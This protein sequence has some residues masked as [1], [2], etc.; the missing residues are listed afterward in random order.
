MTRQ[1]FREFPFSVTLAAGSGGNAPLTH[2]V[3][4]RPA[5]LAFNPTTRVL[6]GTPD[7]TGTLNLVYLVRDTDGDEATDT[8]RIT[9][10][11]PD[12]VVPTDGRP[13]A[14]AQPQVEAV[15]ET[16]LKAIWVAPDAG[17]AAISTYN[18]RVSKS[19]E[20]VWT[21]ATS[22]KSPYIFKELEQGTKYKIQVRAVNS[23]GASNWSA[24]GLAPTHILLEATEAKGGELFD[25]RTDWDKEIIYS[26]KNNGK[27][28]LF[29]NHTDTTGI[30]LTIKTE[31]KTKGAENRLLETD[32]DVR[33]SENVE[34][35]IRGAFDPAVYNDD[36]GRLRF[37]VTKI[38]DDDTLITG[39]AIAILRYP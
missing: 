10:A 39:V 30:N 37:T 23:V 20:D 32:D 18:L 17:D 33:K 19:S 7:A 26:V 34:N 29:F 16:S 5:W 38:T 11:E 22:P 36:E 24:S 31:Q 25:Y 8:F 21:T 3:N 2:A 13:A 4:G 6:S 35:P 15:S 9:V 27:V 12:T 14:P 1:P 28:L